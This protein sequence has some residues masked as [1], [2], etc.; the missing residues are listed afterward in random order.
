[1]R[2]ERI[3]NHRFFKTENAT[4]ITK[5]QRVSFKCLT[6]FFPIGK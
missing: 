1:M 2:K 4:N 5:L 3:A 6:H